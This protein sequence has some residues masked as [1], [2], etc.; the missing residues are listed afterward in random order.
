M[1]AK[2]WSD[3]DMYLEGA[4]IGDDPVLEATRKASRAA[5]LPDSRCRRRRASC[6]I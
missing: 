1:S 3:V 4:L 5:G 6:C 2:L